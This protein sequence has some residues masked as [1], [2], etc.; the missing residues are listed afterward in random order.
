[1]FIASYGLD[2]PSLE[3]AVMARPTKSIVLYYQTIGR[4]LRP[5]PGKEYAI[6]MDHA[7]CVSKHGFI[8]QEPP[9]SLSSDESVSERQEREKKEKKE[10]REI[11]CSVCHTLFKNRRD[12]PSCG[13]RM[14]LVGEPIPHWE[15]D[16]QEI[17]AQ[18]KKNNQVSKT[19]KADFFAMLKGYAFDHGYA[20]GWAAHQYRKKFGVWPN[21]YKDVQ[22]KAP[23][24]E[25]SNWIRSRQ[26]AWAKSK[27][28]A[29]G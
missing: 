20:K 26:I 23:N 1:V 14:V 28:A 18:K 7:D 25:V 8:D 17:E 16:L 11:E 27:K 2:I 6:V 10:P 24:K 19:V 3:V 15:F 21:H 12:C 4:V 29:N 13:H 9:W 22:A 5:S